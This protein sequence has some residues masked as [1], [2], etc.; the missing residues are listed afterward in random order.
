MNELIEWFPQLNAPDLKTQVPQVMTMMKSASFLQSLN[1]YGLSLQNLK[2]E[3]SIF[4]IYAVLGVIT[5]RSVYPLAFFMCF[6]LVN[7]SIFQAI[8]EYQVYLFVMVIYSYVFNSCP[9]KQSKYACV[10]ICLI[11]LSFAIDAFLYG[12]NGYHG[13][14]Q[15]ILW[16][17]IE[18][19][20]TCAHL[21]L[22][23][24]L[25]PIERIRN[26]IR[27]FVNSIGRI[28]LNSDYMFFCWYNIYKI[29]ST[30]Q[31]T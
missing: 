23:S 24:S 19:I 1:V 3:S 11:S 14:R 28:A 22:I 6:L 2:S 15:T 21:I 30:K 16:E 4:F 18:Y 12:V 31:K 10:T 5:K 8:K 26:N 13:T 27:N 9:T 20:A 25:I 7:A 17:S 29:Q